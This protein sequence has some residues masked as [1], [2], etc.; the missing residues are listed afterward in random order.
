MNKFAIKFAV[1][2]AALLCA[3]LVSAKTNTLDGNGFTLTYTGSANALSLSADGSSIVF[4]DLSAGWF[5]RASE[6]EKFK[7]TLDSGYSF[8]SLLV[9]AAG[10]YSGILS[11][12]SATLTSS[13]K[14]SGLSTLSDTQTTSKSS[15]FSGSSW[16]LSKTYDLAST[17]FASASTLNIS[18]S[19]ALSSSGLGT[20]TAQSYTVKIAT[21]PTVVVTPTVPAVPEPGEWAMMLAGLGMIGTIAMRRAR[22]D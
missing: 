21:T 3:G 9:S 2:A 17:S 5:S 10:T 4:N 14:S 19:L 18:S 6:S 13:I 12:T 20:I 7:L 16:S 22:R 15:F 1:F 8:S 11:T